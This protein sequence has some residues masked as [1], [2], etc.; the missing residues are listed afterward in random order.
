[1]E[2]PEN[3]DEVIKGDINLKYVNMGKTVTRRHAELVKTNDGKNDSNTTAK[4]G[5]SKT[6]KTTVEQPAMVRWELKI[7]WFNSLMVLL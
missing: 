6:K 1:M 5:G 3:N 4:K 2:Q 7:I